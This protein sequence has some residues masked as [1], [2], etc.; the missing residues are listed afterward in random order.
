MHRNARASCPD[1][2]MASGHLGTTSCGPRAWT[3]NPLGWRPEPFRPHGR[4]A[5]NCYD[6]RTRC[7]PARLLPRRA[8]M[9]TDITPAARAGQ[10]VRLKY[11]F[12]LT[13]AA[14]L[15]RAQPFAT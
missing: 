13:E 1:D 6:G 15:Q 5:V 12:R 11:V 10:S 7:A 9:T 4:A 3:G 8:V 14:A 2:G